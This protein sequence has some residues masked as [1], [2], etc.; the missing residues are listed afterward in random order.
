ME[1]CRSVSSQRQ[2]GACR[3]AREGSQGIVLLG[4]ISLV[5]D[6]IFCS[7][8]HGKSLTYFNQGDVTGSAFLK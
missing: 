8:N 3:D 5:K 7:K 4:F 1:A 2:C 6:V